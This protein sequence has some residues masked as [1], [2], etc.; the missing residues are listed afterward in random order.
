MDGIIMGAHSLL[1]EQYLQLKQPVV[2][3]DRDLG[4]EIG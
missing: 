3:F 2:A 4:R 1:Q